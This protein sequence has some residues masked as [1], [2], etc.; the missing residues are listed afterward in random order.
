MASKRFPEPLASLK[1]LGIFISLS[2]VAS[3]LPL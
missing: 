1:I 2:M 3:F